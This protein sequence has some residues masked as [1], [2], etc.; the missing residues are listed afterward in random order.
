MTALLCGKRHCNECA[1]VLR[2]TDCI[3]YSDSYCC[4]RTISRINRGMHYF[5][6]LL[7]V[8][9]RR[10]PAH[11][12]RDTCSVH[13]HTHTHLYWSTGKYL[14]CMRKEKLLV[15]FYTAVEPHLTPMINRRLNINRSCVHCRFESSLLHALMSVLHLFLNMYWRLSALSV[16]KNQKSNVLRQL[17]SV[18]TLEELLLHYSKA[19]DAAKRR[20]L[21]R[22]RL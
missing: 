2:S 6:I 9:S 13:T 7:K 12:Q 3:C 15:Q 10:V 8:I 18:T 22:T 1:V 16:N 19:A 20:Y 4:Y 11:T 5:L 14:E 17:S 21:N